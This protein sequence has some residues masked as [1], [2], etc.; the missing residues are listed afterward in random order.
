M[1]LYGLMLG[2]LLIVG[3]VTRFYS[4]H[5]TVLGTTE[6]DS[7]SVHRKC[8]VNQKKKSV[9]ACGIKFAYVS[10]CLLSTVRVSYRAL[11]RDQIILFSLFFGICFHITIT[12]NFNGP[13]HSYV[14]CI[15]SSITF[16]M[17]N[18]R[19]LINCRNSIWR[20]GY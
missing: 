7:L 12:R 15:S 11:C 8:N 20:E 4:E 1:H 18:T 10:H 9:W 17:I 16:N 3:T 5:V 19:K 13:A 2:N 6:Y 14:Y